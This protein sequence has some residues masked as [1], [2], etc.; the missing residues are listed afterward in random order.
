MRALIAPLLAL[1]CLWPQASWGQDKGKGKDKK[2]PVKATEEAPY[3]KVDKKQKGE[4]P[5]VPPKPEAALPPCSYKHLEGRIVVF[6]V[7]GSGNSTLP[8]DNLKEIIRQRKLPILIE[9][10]QWCRFNETRK[11]HNDHEAQ[12]AAGRALA[13]RVLAIRKDAPGAFL[14]F[15][16]YSSGTRV[17][18]A[19]ADALPPGSVDRIF[20]L[21]PSVST[22]Y[23]L[24]PA[25]RASRGGIDSYFSRQDG[26]LEQTEEWLGTSDGVRTATAGRVGFYVPCPP[27]GAGKAKVDHPDLALYKNLRQHQWF[28]E[29]PGNGTH[30]MWVRE[31][32]LGNAIVPQF[33]LI[34]AAA[35]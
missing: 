7:D 14:Y 23:D 15:V 25:L 9:R 35:R 29:D 2:P 21:A 30:Y 17:I 8:S 11:D 13:C 31:R 26:V 16:G 12:L 10:I 18:L 3:P 27:P 20:L 19:A 4:G 28:E 22:F 1:L 32:F 34:Q 33:F 5:K 6:V 24:R